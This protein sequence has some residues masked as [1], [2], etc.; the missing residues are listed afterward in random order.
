MDITEEPY[1]RLTTQPNPEPHTER[2]AGDLVDARRLNQS[3]NIR[4]ISSDSEF[5]NANDLL[6]RSPAVCFSNVLAARLCDW[7]LT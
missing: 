3:L 7:I 5:P 1:K 6:E 2:F 4:E